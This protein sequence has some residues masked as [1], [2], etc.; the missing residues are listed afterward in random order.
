MQKYKHLK[1]QSL[2]TA[3]S[4]STLDLQSI[5]LL[6][7]PIDH[8]K[9]RIVLPQ[10]DELE[11]LNDLQREKQGA[12]PQAD[13]T[14]QP[15]PPAKIVKKLSSYEQELM[16]L[17]MNFNL[18]NLTTLQLYLLQH[19][20][21]VFKEVTELKQK[22]EAERQEAIQRKLKPEQPGTDKDSNED[23]MTV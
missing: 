18:K 22:Y 19:F 10:K 3:Y 5:T 6:S 21:S 14:N 12:D 8:N 4:Q 1:D 2:P 9:K 15:K 17:L 13:L 16:F 23:D 20:N 7:I 11:L